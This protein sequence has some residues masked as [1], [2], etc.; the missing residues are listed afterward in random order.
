MRVT[1]IVSVMPRLSSS[2]AMSAADRASPCR[3]RSR[4]TAA[5]SRP[6]RPADRT[7][8]PARTARLMVTAGVVGVC[9][10]QQRRRRCRADACG[11]R[12]A[13]RTFGP[14]YDVR[15]S[16]VRECSRLEPA[17]GSVRWRRDAAAPRRRLSST[18]HRGDPRAA[19]S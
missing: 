5:T 13:L 19:A 8:E 6:A 4:A 16:T 18:R 3:G 12:P 10:G 14:F 2:S 11:A 17:D 9:L 1:A 7:T 15:R